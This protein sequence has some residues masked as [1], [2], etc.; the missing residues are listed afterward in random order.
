MAL[1]S[2]CFFSC[3]RRLIFPELGPIEDSPP[4]PAPPAEEPALSFVHGMI[5]EEQQRAVMDVVQ[6]RQAHAPYII[7]G[8][9]GTGKTLTLIEAI[10]Q[11]RHAHIYTIQQRNRTS[12]TPLSERNQC[13]CSL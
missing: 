5:N 4:F 6:G 9:P 13:M 12:L 8:P 1:L 3:I 2:L 10:I 7:F 11:V